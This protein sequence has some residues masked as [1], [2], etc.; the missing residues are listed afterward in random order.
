[1]VPRGVSRRREAW[2]SK[3]KGVGVG[4]RGGCQATGSSATRPSC[5]KS[6]SELQA[7]IPQWGAGVTDHGRV[8]VPCG[9]CAS[10][11]TTRTG[12]TTWS[13]RGVRGE[14]RCAMSSQRAR[15]KR[16][17]VVHEPSA[18]R[19]AAIA[20]EQQTRTHRRRDTPKAVW[21]CRASRLRYSV[22]S[23]EARP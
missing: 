5:I 18:S 13:W 17:A 19:D 2:A 23:S 15:Q 1:M 4:M 7:P 3:E 11:E 8:I 14:V 21:L 16:L 10:A 12:L 9:R 20:A 6:S 22:L